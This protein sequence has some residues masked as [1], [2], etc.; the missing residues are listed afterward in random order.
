MAMDWNGYSDPYALMFFCNQ[1]MRSSIRATDL[2]PTWNETFAFLLP[3]HRVH[4]HEELFIAVR[5]HWLFALTF[6]F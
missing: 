5:G 6:F 3:P 2:N 4:E 1:E